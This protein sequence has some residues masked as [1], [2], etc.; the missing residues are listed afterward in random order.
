[1]NLLISGAA[2]G[3][4][5]C[6]LRIA[7]GTITEIDGRLRP[8]PDE[9]VVAAAGAAVIPG[10]HDHH[11]H[12]HAM[13]AAMASVQ[14]GPP[15]VV[16]EAALVAALREADRSLPPA[17][18]IRGVGY[19]E[20]VAGAMDRDALDRIVGHRPTRIQHSTGGLWILNSA[21]IAALRLQDATTNDG[22]IE[23]DGAGRPTGRLWRSDVVIRGELARPPDVSGVG[24]TLLSLGITSVTDAT[25]DLDAVAIDHLEKSAADGGLPQRVV[26]LGAP[27]DW[28]G[29]AVVRGPRKLLLPDHDLPSLD[30]LSGSIR[31][32]H[33]VGRPVAV[34][35]V[36]RESL[37][38]TLAALDDVGVLKGD[39]IEHGSVVPSEVRGSIAKLG[40]A[41]VT[42]PGF[43][44]ER[45]DRY[46]TDVDDDDLDLLYPYATLQGAGVDVAPSSD[47][48]YADPDPWR[49]MTAARDRRTAGGVVLGAQESVD[50]AV[51]LSGYL[52]DGH[53]PGGP[54]RSLAVG[55]RAELCL[56]T[57]PLIDAL[58]EPHR[59]NVRATVAGDRVYVRA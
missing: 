29:T 25:P 31:Q 34:H 13:A 37:L 40:L 2:V 5:V 1:M 4:R 41:V 52:S 16:S 22:G 32:A 26:A 8:R 47:A 42:Q 36:T 43:V 20:S 39:R 35:C 57:V 12:L 56:L 30:I 59:D 17:D 11:L 23:V 50:P 38:L 58:R 28:V 15:A 10:L 14:C 3:D 44:C 24:E 49:T 53:R 33:E 51:V 18:W 7:A 55:R 6:D 48:P 46:L 27:D 54:A 9:T 19:H 45:G 21:A